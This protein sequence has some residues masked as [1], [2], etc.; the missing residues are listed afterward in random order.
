MHDLKSSGTPARGSW[1]DEIWRAAR[2]EYVVTATRDGATLDALYGGAAFQGLIFLRAIR[3]GKDIGWVSVL[4]T[5][6]TNHRHFGNLRVGSIVDGFC[7]LADAAGLVAAATRFLERR[8]VDLI[9]SNQLHEAW[10][11]GLTASGFFRGPSNFALALSKALAA[12]VAVNDA[13]WGTLH[14]NRGDGDG[15]INL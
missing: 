4:D 11:R 6:M 1:A 14:F 3:A 7:A 2:A 9:V 10:V 13:Q 12:A 15:P 8:G 5:P